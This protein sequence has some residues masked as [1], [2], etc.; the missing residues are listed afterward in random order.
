MKTWNITLGEILN[1][2]TYW[3]PHQERIRYRRQWHLWRTVEYSTSSLWLECYCKAP[4]SNHQYPWS[5][6]MKSWW[7][8]TNRTTATLLC[9]PP[10][11]GTKHWEKSPVGWIRTPAMARD[12]SGDARAKDTASSAVKRAE[13]I[14]CVGVS[15]ECLLPGRK[16]QVGFH[17][18]AD[19]SCWG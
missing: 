11:A 4:Y 2:G 3:F 19:K 13:I 9:R 5:I 12:S 7:D 17:M 1:R 18:R 8:A 16:D 14:M 6:Y 10:P 15:V